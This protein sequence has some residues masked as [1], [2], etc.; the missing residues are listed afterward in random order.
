VKTPDHIRAAAI[1]DYRDGAT[2]KDIAERYSLGHATVSRIM[3]A[4][5]VRRTRETPAD[6]LA[7][8]A[9]D[10]LESGE[11]AKAVAKRHEISEN[12]LRV[13]LKK[14]GLTRPS[15]SLVNA[16]T[17]RAVVADYANGLPMR[18]I[19]QHHGVSA[20]AVLAWAKTAGVEIRKP[21]YRSATGEPIAYEGGWEL[22]GGVHRPLAPVRHLGAA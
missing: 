13:E 4:A 18:D 7:V 15:G 16:A 11:N 3:A 8:A 6:V 9:A 1:A 21:G 10:Y 5:G 19:T 20:T 14:R 22:I 17:R 2:Q 12:A